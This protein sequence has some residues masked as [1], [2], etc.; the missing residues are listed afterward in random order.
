MQPKITRKKK[1]SHT[2]WTN[3]GDNELVLNERRK[4]LGVAAAALARGGVRGWG[5]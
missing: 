4:Q 2:L 5:G 3:L 1:V